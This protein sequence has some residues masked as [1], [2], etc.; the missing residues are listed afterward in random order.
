MI[1][2][3]FFL[4]TSIFR[5]AFMIIITLWYDWDAV[6]AILVISHVSRDN[7]Q[8]IFFSLSL[9]WRCASVW[10]HY[11]WIREW[12]KRKNAHIH[13]MFGMN[14]FLFGNFFVAILQRAKPTEKKRKVKVLRLWLLCGWRWII[15]FWAFENCYFEY[16]PRTYERR[17]RRCRSRLFLHAALYFIVFINYS[18]L[19]RVIVCRSLSAKKKCTQNT[20][21]IHTEQ[22]NERVK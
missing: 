19:S 21:Q 20:T 7:R 3:I 9:F 2:S 18:R 15:S 17:R 1:L 6:I 14:F 12:K 5:F 8:L 16:A 11:L 22:E 4:S 10:I 13:R